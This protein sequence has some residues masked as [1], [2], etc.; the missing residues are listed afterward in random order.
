MSALS[1]GLAWVGAQ[2]P[3]ATLVLALA[4]TADLLLAGRVAPVWRAA[5][6]WVA[7]AR[8]AVPA[9]LTAPWAVWG[10]AVPPL[11]GRHAGPLVPDLFPWVWLPWVWAIGCVLLVGAWTL[12]R[13][14]H[15]RALSRTARPLRG[16]AAARLRHLAGTRRVRACVDPGTRTPYVFGLWRPCIVLPAAL[17]RAQVDVAL[18]HEWCHV[19]RKDLWAQAAWDLAALVLWFHP[20]VWVARQ[21]AHHVRE[22]CCDADVARR[23]DPRAYRHT[24]LELAMQA[25][26]PRAG[27]AM[28]RSKSSVLDRVSHLERFVHVR[29]RAHAIA[30]LTLAIAVAAWLFPR[31]A[32][33]DGSGMSPAEQRLAGLLSGKRDT[34]G[35]EL[36]AATF[37]LLVEQK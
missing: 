22:L 25:T 24:L 30:A 15:R 12:R 33:S 26:V 27:A 11:P 3:A 13:V 34:G 1:D 21:R 28:G 10:S 36:R 7:L 16:D 8:I 14:R 18:R 2:V 31:S 29:H 17:S 19:R 20:L 35:L 5:F 6:F 37:A 23:T 32:P 4:L 9:S